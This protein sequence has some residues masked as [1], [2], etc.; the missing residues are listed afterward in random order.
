MAGENQLWA[1]LPGET[2]EIIP[3]NRDPAGALH[4]AVPGMVRGAMNSA[5][6]ALVGPGEILTG[7]TPSGANALGVSPEQVASDIT[8]TGFGLGAGRVPLPGS[9][10]MF[11][12]VRSPAADLSKLEI[13]K[14]MWDQGASPREVIDQTK[15]FKGPD[16]QWRFEIPD[17]VATI[18]TSEL[19]NFKNMGPNMGKPLGALLSHP[20]LYEAYPGLKNTLVKKTTSD[21]N[22]YGAYDSK[23]NL[24]ALNPRFPLEDQ[25]STA[26]HEIQ[27][28]VQQHEGFGA[29]GNIREFFPKG[30]EENYSGWKKSGENLDLL[31][32]GLGV[33]PYLARAGIRND[34]NNL[35]MTLGQRIS[36]DKLAEQMPSLPGA[37]QRHLEI[38]A[39]LVK[40]YD[41][42]FQKYSS[43]AGEIESRTVEARKAAGEYTVPPWLTEGYPTGEQGVRFKPRTDFLTPGNEHPW[44]TQAIATA[45]EKAKSFEPVEHNPWTHK[46]EPVEHDPFAGS[47]P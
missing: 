23:N 36:V 35:P 39:P 13:A 15:W 21:A 29:G 20:E 16:E 22:V 37:L 45:A 24:I 31:A 14:K 34:M 32:Q 42:A 4:F 12:G 7:K 46:I 40:E 25:L 47:K 9:V 5:Y 11:A 18:N 2:G 26:L 30:F 44:K 38:G 43:L 10:G 8:A 1:E 33:D 41:K 28:A 17:A 3:L 27:H 6:N 19:E